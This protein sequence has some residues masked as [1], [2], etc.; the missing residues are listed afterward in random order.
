MPSQRKQ[1]YL[2]QF[3]ES[4]YSSVHLYVSNVGKKILLYV[5]VGQEQE[6]REL[7]RKAE[8]KNSHQSQVLLQ[9]IGSFKLA[10]YRQC[11]KNP[12]IRNDDETNC[13]EVHA[14]DLYWSW[15][16]WT[17]ARETGDAKDEGFY[18]TLG[19]ETSI[20]HG[21]SASRDV[22]VKVQ[23]TKCNAHLS[24]LIKHP[25]LKN[26]NSW[27]YQHACPFLSFRLEQHSTAEN[28]Y[29]KETDK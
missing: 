3:V 20:L 2:G 4:S 14:L 25:P 1:A 22:W 10:N 15:G 7:L 19:I 11:L 23:S 28:L 27:F 5:F 12:C 6:A 13:F 9:V 16:Q 24:V 21:P 26:R 29:E 8:A 18:W 17:K